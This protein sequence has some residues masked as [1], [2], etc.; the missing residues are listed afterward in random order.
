MLKDWQVLIGIG[1]IIVVLEMTRRTSL[2]FFVLALAGIAYTIYGNYMTGIFN[3]PGMT[4][5]R[6]VYL[7]TFT[8]EGIFG[9]GLSVVQ[10]TYLFL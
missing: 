3:H 7:T 4:L 10:L 1:M 5:K 2:P 9:L 6:M 8:E